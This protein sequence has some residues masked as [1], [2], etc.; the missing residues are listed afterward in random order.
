[1]HVTVAGLKRLVG[2][3][4][5]LIDALAERL[6]GCRNRVFNLGARTGEFWIRQ[7]LHALKQIL[8]LGDEFPHLLMYHCPGLPRRLAGTLYT[9]AA[10]ACPRGR[11]I[12]GCVSH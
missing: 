6:S 8:D 3:A 2:A 1:V 10:I 11:K 12:V 4:P 9:R 7:V 5:H